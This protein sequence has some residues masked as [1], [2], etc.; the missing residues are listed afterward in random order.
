VIREVEGGVEV[1]LHLQPRASRTE[2]VGMHGGALKLRIAAPPVDGEAND[3]LVR[4]LAKTLGVTKSRVT[5]V[6]GTTG[7]RKRVRLEGVGIKDVEER[8]RN[9]RP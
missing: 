4:F 6:S 1:S 3:E 7:R 8:L 5:I 9:P 2:I